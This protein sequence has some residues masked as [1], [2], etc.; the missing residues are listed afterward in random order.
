MMNNEIIHTAIW[1]GRMF[2]LAASVL[3]VRLETVYNLSVTHQ[4]LPQQSP[5]RAI[6]HQIDA[7]VE[8][9]PRYKPVNP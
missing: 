2:V 4:S 6:P 9:I 5:Q 3:R 8:A 7:I 1:A